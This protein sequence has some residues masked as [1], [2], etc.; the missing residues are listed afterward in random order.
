MFM[1]VYKILQIKLAQWSLIEI[2]FPLEDSPTLASIYVRSVTV[3]SS[4]L[5][6]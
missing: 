6:A 1:N 5:E 4:F 3:L 2:I